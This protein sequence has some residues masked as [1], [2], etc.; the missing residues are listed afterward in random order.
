[1]G[2]GDSSGDAFHLGPVATFKSVG[3]WC[4]LRLNPYWLTISDQ[5]GVNFLREMLGFLLGVT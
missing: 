4:Y 1:M 2:R 5:K 3:N